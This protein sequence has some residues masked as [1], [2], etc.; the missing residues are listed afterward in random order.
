VLVAWPEPAPGG[1]QVRVATLGP[2][3]PIGAPAALPG[4]HIRGTVAL[5]DEGDRA[6]AAWVARLRVRAIEIPATH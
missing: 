4:R 2:T 6:L 1:G 3:G 5:A